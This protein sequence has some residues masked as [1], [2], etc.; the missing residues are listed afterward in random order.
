VLVVK[1]AEAAAE[2]GHE[3]LAAHVGARGNLGSTKGSTNRKRSSSKRSSKGSTN[4]KRSSGSGSSS[5]G[6]GGSGGSAQQ[7]GAGRLS[8]TG[9][10]PRYLLCRT[11]EPDVD[12]G[13]FAWFADFE[14]D[15]VP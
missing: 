4:R 10:G 3:V 11:R 7:G 2:A 12:T 8:K 6:S 9:R 14:E 5:G 1:V 13:G 15:A